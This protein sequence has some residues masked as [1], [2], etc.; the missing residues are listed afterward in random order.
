MFGHFNLISGQFF[1]PVRNS[2]LS[3]LP[4]GNVDNDSLLISHCNFSSLILSRVVS[5]SSY[6]LSKTFS[7]KSKGL[8][9]ARVV[10]ITGKECGS[11]VYF[12]KDS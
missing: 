4:H 2:C 5:I 12:C 1:S 11:A 8:S 7:I 6:I 10:S 9:D 3:I